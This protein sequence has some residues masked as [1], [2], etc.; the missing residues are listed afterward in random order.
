MPPSDDDRH[1]EP[2]VPDQPGR[3]TLETP[4][5]RRDDDRRGDAP[6]R[7]PA[8]IDVRPAAH[9]G[10]APIHRLVATVC[11]PACVLGDADGQ[12]RPAGVAGLYVG[13]TRALRR[14]VITID[15][16]EPDALGWSMRPQAGAGG[17]QSLPTP[18]AVPGRRSGHPLISAWSS[19]DRSGPPTKGQ[20]L[21]GGPC[22]AM[23][24]WR[25]C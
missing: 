2:P 12:L 15:G 8:Q 10:P 25:S 18:V 6:A 23:G 9:F 14:A 13:D 17:H 16:A 7:I 22:P 11:A 20:L 19:R 1:A 3:P 4:D 5:E 21:A 24:V